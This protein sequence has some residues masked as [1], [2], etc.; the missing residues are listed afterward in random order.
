MATYTLTDTQRATLRNALRVAAEQYEKDAKAVSGVK[1]LR[2]QFI[3]Q[4]R[5]VSELDALLENSVEV[6]F[7]T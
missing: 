2:D 1:R 6:N 4:Q 7:C 3:R 5:E